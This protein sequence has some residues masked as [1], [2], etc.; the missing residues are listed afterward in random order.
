VRVQNAE[1][2]DNV[3]DEVAAEGVESFRSVELVDGGVLVLV[4]VWFI[5]NRGEG[6]RRDTGM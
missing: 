2:S 6:R 1:C 4:R 5:D 3:W